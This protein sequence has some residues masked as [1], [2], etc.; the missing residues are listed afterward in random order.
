MQCDSN[1]LTLG[2][3]NI[4]RS[5]VNMERRMC[6]QSESGVVVSDHTTWEQSKLLITISTSGSTRPGSE[7]LQNQERIVY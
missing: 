7:L 4:I 6:V 1:M 5:Y 2:T 3:Q